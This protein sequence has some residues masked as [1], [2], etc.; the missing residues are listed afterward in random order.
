ML[1]RTIIYLLK[2]N[3]SG[4]KHFLVSTFQNSIFSA[5]LNLSCIFGVVLSLSI[6]LSRSRDTIV[7]PVSAVVVTIYATYDGR[8]SERETFGL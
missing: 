3:K 7:S 1:I 2:K 4:I 6:C 5:C 8:I